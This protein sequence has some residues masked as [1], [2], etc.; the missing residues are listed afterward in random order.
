MLTAGQLA[1]GGGTI[2]NVETNDDPKVFQFQIG[3][4]NGEIYV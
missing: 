3:S 1:P 4:F 2:Y